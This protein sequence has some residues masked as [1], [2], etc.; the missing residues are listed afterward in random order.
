MF[1]GDIKPFYEDICDS[2]EVEFMRATF[3][4]DNRCFDFTLRNT[5]SFPVHLGS[6]SFKNIT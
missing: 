3:T 5:M 1:I 4:E 6:E 2:T